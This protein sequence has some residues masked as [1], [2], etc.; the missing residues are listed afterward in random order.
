VTEIWP[1]S[2]VLVPLGAHPHGGGTTF[3]VFSGVASPVGTTVAGETFP[4]RPRSVVVLR[5]PG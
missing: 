1:G 3:A 2:F 4:L 5:A